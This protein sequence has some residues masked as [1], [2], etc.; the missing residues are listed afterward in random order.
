MFGLVKCRVNFVDFNFGNSSGW[1][2]GGG[3]TVDFK[4]VNNFFVDLNFGKQFLSS[5]HK[6][7]IFIK[8]NLF[9]RDMVF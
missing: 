6:K 8:E 7:Y 9:L 2:R 5:F 3:E 1:T 4:P